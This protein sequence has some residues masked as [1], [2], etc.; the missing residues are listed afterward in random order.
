M[1]EKEEGEKGKEGSLTSAY[2]VEK[3]QRTEGS[4]CLMGHASMGNHRRSSCR[5]AD[6]LKA[7][8][9]P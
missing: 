9:Q 1:E 5:K 6:P 2:R 3:L 8:F 7:D 4:L